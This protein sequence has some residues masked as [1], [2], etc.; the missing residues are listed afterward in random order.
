M[1]QAPLPQNETER[2][3]SLRSCG[4]LDSKAER[5]FDDLVQI[6]AE[7]FEVPVALVSLVD[8]HRQWFKARFG[9]E[10]TET[11]RDVAF[12]S[13]AIADPEAVLVVEDSLKDP[14]FVDNPLVTSGPCVR[15]YAGAPLVTEDGMA[16]GT[17]CVIDSEP[18]QFSEDKI[19]SLRALARQAVAQIE[20]RKRNDVLSA[21]SRELRSAN[22][23]LRDFT[24]AAAHD[25][26]EPLR[27]LVTFA[28]LLTDDL[29]SELSEAAERDLDLIVDAAS[30]MEHMVAGLLRLSRSGT[31]P[32]QVAE[33]PLRR[34]VDAA[35]K[36]LGARVAET[37]ATVEIDALPA[38][39]G[40]EALLTQLFQNLVSNALK[41]I[42]GREPKLR[43]TCVEEEGSRVYG[44]RDNGIG[45]EEGDVSAILAPFKRLHARADYPGS[46]MGLAICHKIVERHGGRIWVESQPGVGSHFQFTLPGL[47]L[48][49]GEDARGDRGHL[50]GA[51]RTG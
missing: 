33:V 36:A 38:V 14:R 28:S 34:C 24:A 6:A 35:L 48:Q 37:G 2:L 13:H 26:R 16:L 32:L 41:F 5:D 49:C 19:R 10:A 4:L 23:D 7:L 11:A 47:A 20:L 18:R 43:V 29:D 9:L 45:I 31:M 27:K 12:C 51:R 40:D 3:A 1:I 8:A 30:R 15:F 25:L 39:R 44:V 50:D 22:D 42:A 21:L 17:L 46:G